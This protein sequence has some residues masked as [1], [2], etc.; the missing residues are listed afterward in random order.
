MSKNKL[1]NFYGG[2]EF[3]QA[4][5]KVRRDYQVDYEIND[6]RFGMRND[7]FW[8]IQIGWILPIYK[9]SPKEFYY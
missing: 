1:M 2:I 7:N 5:T 6:P 4:Y 3:N 8:N 9:R